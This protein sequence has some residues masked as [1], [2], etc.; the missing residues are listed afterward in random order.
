MMIVGGAA[1]IG[2]AIVGG[3]AGTVLII[4]GSAVGLVGLWRHLQ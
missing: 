1:I 3:K 2:G 4:G